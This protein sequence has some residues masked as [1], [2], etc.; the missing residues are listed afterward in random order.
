METSGLPREDLVRKLEEWNERGIINLKPSGVQ[1]VY[2][3]ERPLPAT[4]QEIERIVDQLDETMGAQEKQNLDRT[5]ALIDLI[6][7]KKCFSRSL[8]EY[9]GEASGGMPEECGHCTWCE[10]HEQ[11]FLPNEPPQPPD[12]G[13]VKRILKEVPA[14]DDPRYLA[15]IAFGIKSPRMTQEGIYKTGVFE[16]MNVC[17]FEELVKIFTKECRM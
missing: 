9:F 5:K 16:S 3:L 10:T 8:A 14:R 7:D 13:L 15:K 6:T 2:R 12:P 11:V 4:K 17:D 1:Q